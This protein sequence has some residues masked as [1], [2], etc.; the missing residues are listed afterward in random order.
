M[1]AS[2][3]I[4]P[5]VQRA[6]CALYGEEYWSESHCED[7]FISRFDYLADAEN[8]IIESFTEAHEVPDSLLGYLDEQAI[9]RDLLI[10]SYN[11]VDIKI[12]GQDAYFLFLMI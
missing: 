8:Y 7:A 4:H 6:Y 11:I 10:D 12:D 2:P 3:S 5:D 9:L 1:D